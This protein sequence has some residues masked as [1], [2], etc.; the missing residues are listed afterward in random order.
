MIKILKVIKKKTPKLSNLNFSLFFE[1]WNWNEKS[2]K[3]EKLEKEK[4]TSERKKK[5]LEREEKTK[6][7]KVNHHQYKWREINRETTKQAINE[8]QQQCSN[9]FLNSFFFIH[10]K[11]KQEKRE[12]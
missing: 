1:K 11:K 12:K 10:E 9:Y 4:K 3:S 2:P 7:P 6:A 8:T 5:A